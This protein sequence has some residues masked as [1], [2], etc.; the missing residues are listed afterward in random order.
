VLR[1]RTSGSAVTIEI[2]DDGRG[3]EWEAVRRSA[4]RLGVRSESRD[5]LIKALF[6]DGLTTKA[7]CSEVSGRGVGMSALLTSV[8]ALHGKLDIVSKPGSGTVVRIALALDDIAAHR[9]WRVISTTA[10]VASPVA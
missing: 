5:D 10:S 2:E 8:K 3:I 6:V 7:E 9:H 1:A 4:R